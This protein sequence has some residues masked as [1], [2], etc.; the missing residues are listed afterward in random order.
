MWRS[1]YVYKKLFILCIVWGPR[2]GIATIWS[3]R[4]GIVGVSFFLRTS[5]AEKKRNPHQ[6]RKKINGIRIFSFWGLLGIICF[7][8]N[9]V[10][11]PQSVKMI[12]QKKIKES[13]EV[14]YFFLRNQFAHGVRPP[15]IKH[16]RR[17]INDLSAWTPNCK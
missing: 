17:R 10:Y 7:K 5:S 15:L 2:A 16:A 11:S 14:Q 3:P 12:P 1:R 4:A 9:S 13:A 8:I 6:F